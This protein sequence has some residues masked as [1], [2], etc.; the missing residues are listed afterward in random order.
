MMLVLRIENPEGVEDGSPTSLQLNGRGARVG[1]RT[2]MDWVLPDPSRVIS[3]HHFDITFDAGVYYLTDTSTNGT[4]IVGSRER[5]DRTIPVRGGERIVV[6]RYII[7]M[8]L[9]PQPAAE[10]SRPVP[11]DRIAL[12]TPMGPPGGPEV[13]PPQRPQPDAGPAA[14]A[15]RGALQMPSHQAFPPSGSPPGQRL[16]QPGWTPPSPSHLAVQDPAP[17]PQTDTYTIVSDPGRPVAG[18]V[19][20]G[21]HPAPATSRAEARHAPEAEARPEPNPAAFAPAPPAASF[22]HAD[23][24]ATHAAKLPETPPEPSAE[25]AVALT[26]F[27]DAAGLPRDAVDL[28]DPAAL[29]DRLG[30]SAR[31]AVEEIMHLLQACAAMQGA[32]EGDDRTMLGTARAN[33]MKQLPSSR[34]ALGVMFGAPRAGF[35]T[36]PE[37]FQEALSELRLHERAMLEALQP[38]LAE[39]FHGLSPA[40][41]EAEATDGR[42]DQMWALYRQRWQAKAG[43]GDAGLVHAF[44]EAFARAYAAA[45]AA[46]DDDNENR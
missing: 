33:P 1:R 26:A 32:V 2:T 21:P 36:G 45:S 35:L 5:L 6:G 41:I 38:A 44:F 22:P 39:V 43:P 3:G 18:P 19:P 42:P 20:T 34:E 25:L 9:R 27:C 46:A 28:E 37:S 14:P 11:S 7:A 8:E 13:A 10:P 17:P 4:F 40:E 30:R 12:R 31:I 23:G 16:Q 29:M 15:G 24:G